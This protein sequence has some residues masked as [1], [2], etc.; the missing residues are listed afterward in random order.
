MASYWDKVF[1][2]RITRRRAIRF[3]GLAAGTA[4]LLA[5]CNDDKEDAASGDEAARIGSDGNPADRR[6]DL[7]WRPVD[8]TSQ[9]RRGGSWK[10]VGLKDP[11]S[12]N[13][14]NFDPYAQGFANT[15]G[16]KLVY[17]SPARLRD[18]G[19]FDVKGDLAEDW[20]VS[21]D[22]L[23]YTFK[24]NPNKKFGPFSPTFHAGAPESIA[25]RVIDSEDVL[26]SWDRFKT[27]SSNGSEFANSEDYPNA[28]IISVEAPD[29]TTVVMKLKQPYSPLLVQ[30]ANASVSYFYVIPKEGKEE[31][32][33]FLDKYMFGGG[34]FFIDEFK[35]GEDLILKRNPNFEDPEGLLRPYA[36]D[37]HYQIV[38]DPAEQLARFRAGEIFLAP[39]NFTTEASLALKEEIPELLMWALPDSSAVAEWFGMGSDGPWKDERVRQA[40]QYTWDRDLFIDVVFSTQNL[41]S[42]GIPSNR[43]WNT[44]IPCGGPGSYMFFPGMWL[45]PQSGEFGEN[46]KYFTLGSPDANIS[47][48]KRLLSA[49]GY[50]EGLDFTHAQFTLTSGQDPARDIV[51]V[52]RVIADFAQIADHIG[53]ADARPAVHQQVFVLGNLR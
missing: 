21:E 19:A 41:E 11:A 43:R 32:S 24:L 29:A 6:S 13:I 38:S 50:P 44:A 27:V 23:T 10:A 5:A 42:L 8:T 30:L 31:S 37:V 52:L 48:A 49:A 35:P 4:A 17:L 15:I 33:D 34:P 9:A 45:D 39:T 12:F 46:A 16:T 3:I 14:Y 51:H 20:E 47:E 7:L 40:V 18:P 53:A 26:Y 2:R 28:P 22:K 36:D 1:K 25:N